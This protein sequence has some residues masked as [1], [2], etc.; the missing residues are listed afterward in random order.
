MS[1]A[2][3]PAPRSRYG[4]LINIDAVAEELWKSPSGEIQVRSR[5]VAIAVGAKDLGYCVVTLA[6]G[7]SSCPFHFHHSE[8][9]VFHVLQGH[10]ELRQGDGT[11]EDERLQLGPGDV[12]AFPPGT[13]IAHRFYNS[14]QA[15]FVYFALSNRLPY[16]V[17]EYPDSD[18]VLIRKTRMMLR[19]G[20]ILD[21]FEGEA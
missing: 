6:P 13:R 10:A 8:E 15:P 20:P 21:Y 1:E 3:P 11:G 5:E 17:A 9:E 7:S 4:N 14:S 2:T 19:R 12:V 18:K 16:D